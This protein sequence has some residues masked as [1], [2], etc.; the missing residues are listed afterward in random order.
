MHLLYGL[1]FFS[2]ERVLSIKWPTV[3]RSGMY[4]ERPSPTFLTST[5]YKVNNFQITLKGILEPLFES[6][7]PLFSTVVPSVQKHDIFSIYLIRPLFPVPTAF[8]SWAL[9]LWNTCRYQYFDL[10][11]HFCYF[12]ICNLNLTI[13]FTPATSNSNLQTHPNNRQFTWKKYHTTYL[14]T[15]TPW[16]LN[17]RHGLFWE[18]RKDANCTTQNTWIHDNKYTSDK[19]RVS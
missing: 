9:L 18:G 4:F 1:G 13:K 5:M 3:I 17:N 7:L 6:I 14:E 8:N 10:L 15:P 12:Q 19:N 2:K 11:M 16:R